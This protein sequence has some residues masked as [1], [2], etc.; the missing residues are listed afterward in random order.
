MERQ[1]P[2]TDLAQIRGSFLAISLVRWSRA[3]GQ[4]GPSAA[5]QF[6]RRHQAG[7]QASS[8]AVGGAMGVLL[9]P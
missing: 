3:T 2:K 1:G 7:R 8:S 9:G 4:D 6:P 5:G